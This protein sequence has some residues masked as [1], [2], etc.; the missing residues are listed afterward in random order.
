MP[1][2]IAEINGKKY[3]EVEDDKAIFVHADGTEAPFD[4]EGTLAR[5]TALNAE[6]TG[7]RH[8]INDLKKKLAGFEGIED[9][10]AAKK[11]LETM[12]NL[13]VGELKTAAQVAEI[14]TAA[15]KAAEE[16]VA[17]A[18]K[19]AAEDLRKANE[20]KDK[21]QAELFSEKV[22]GNFA[23]S[24]FVQEKLSIPADIAQNFFGQNFKVVDGKLEAYFPTGEKIYSKTRGGE[25]ATFDEAIEQL[26]SSYPNKDHILKGVGG[27]GG[28]NGN[29]GKNKTDKEKLKG[30]SPVQRMNIARGAPA[31]T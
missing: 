6:S 25:L 3:V 26:V 12:A 28:A 11:A 29:D 10:E 16:Q 18:Q 7:R 1:Y 24:K 20:E 17:S 30:M 21:L 27:G 31:G 14:K 8:E 13:Q 4:A 2:K 22:G 5:V 19:K 9:P 23:R 15:Q